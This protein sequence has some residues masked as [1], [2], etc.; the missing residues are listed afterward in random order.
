[1]DVR[2]SSMIVIVTP[3]IEDSA[4]VRWYASEI[5]ANLGHELVS[6]SR[7]RV[8]FHGDL[9]EDPEHAKELLDLAYRT[10][11]RIRAGEDVGDLATHRKGLS[12]ALEL[13][14]TASPQ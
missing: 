9:G 11:D 14:E 4:V 7:Y 1:M 13:V 3:T 12:G 2:V 8:L 6:A 10:R 5:A